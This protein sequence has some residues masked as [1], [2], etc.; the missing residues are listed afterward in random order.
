M[1]GMAM[2][3]GSSPKSAAGERF[4]ASLVDSSDDAIVGLTP[5]G[6]V[7]SWNGAAERLFGYSAEEMLGR[8]TTPLVPPQRRGELA[9]ALARV[10]SG[11]TLRN[12]T[13]E[14]LRKDGTPL[15]VS[16]TA[17]PVIGP[18]GTL[19]GMS[20]IGRDMTAQVDA[21]QRRRSSERSATEALALLQTLQ[22]SAPV[23]FGFV[24]RE[25]RVRRLNE[26]FCTF[27]G[28]PADRELAGRPAPEVMAACWA[29]V[30]PLLRQ[31]C[32]AGE[33]VVNAELTTQIPAEPG[34]ARHWLTSFYPVRID[35]EIVGVGVVALDI[36]ARKQAEEAH[37]RLTRAAVGALASAVES[38]DPYTDGH[39]SRTATIACAIATELGLDEGTVRGIEMAARIHDIGKIAIPAEI[40]TSPKRLNAP[41]WELMKLHA[42]TGADIVRGVE[43][44]H[45]VADTVEQH[46]ER[47]DGSGY[48]NGL[49]GEEILFGARIIAVA[50][51]LDAMT[52]H[53][54]YRPARAIDAALREID[55]QR[56]QLF[57][58][59]VVD[60]CVSLVRE[61]R[62]DLES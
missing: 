42:T 46:H 16:I 59:A 2:S 10:R 41:S 36:T 7:T 8:D 9:E 62:L 5:Q 27:G 26:T 48:P 3:S 56:G 40:L 21:A 12:V 55:E 35:D 44:S 37:M 43:F 38:R 31:V 49:H 6:T 58:P 19:L 52:E 32:D 24:D 25:L 60:A 61:R 17:S 28:L 45:R 18:D 23:G 15:V 51:T 13:T 50:D 20:A 29:Q 33:A 22:D 34:G 39:Q 57:E 53:R 1:E 14:R 4:L 47:L 11:E 54:P 30:E